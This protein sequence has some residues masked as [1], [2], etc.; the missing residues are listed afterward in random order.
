M[1]NSLKTGFS[2]FWPAKSGRNKMVA[3]NRRCNSSRFIRIRNPF[4]SSVHR[5]GSTALGKNRF[6]PVLT[7]LDGSVRHQNLMCT[8][9]AQAGFLCQVWARSVQA[10]PRK[11]ADTHTHTQTHGKFIEWVL[12]RSAKLTKN[13]QGK[14][15]KWYFY[16]WDLLMH[17]NLLLNKHLEMLLRRLLSNNVWSWW[18]FRYCNSE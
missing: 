7:T 9:G 4:R 1:Q 15:M 3:R 16:V 5:L 8:C 12:H 18:I 10:D 2:Q 6:F 17:N 13:K 14:S 11:D